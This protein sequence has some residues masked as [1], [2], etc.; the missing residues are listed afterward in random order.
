MNKEAVRTAIAEAC[1]WSDIK[2]LDNWECPC[3]RPPNTTDQYKPSPDYLNDLNAMHKAKKTLTPIQREQYIVYLY[4]VVLGDGDYNR[5]DDQ[6][7]VHNP[8]ADQEAEAFLKT[9]GKWEE[10]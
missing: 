3:G 4:C 7:K 6:W 9:V 2:K 10:G 5:N 1:G 8:S